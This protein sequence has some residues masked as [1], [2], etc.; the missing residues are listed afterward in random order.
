MAGLGIAL[1]AEQC[2]RAVERQLA[3]QLLDADGIE[4]L[5]DIAAGVLRSQLDARSLAHALPCI[6]RVLEMAP[7]GCRRQLATVAALDRGLS[8]RILESRGRSPGIFGGAEA[9]PLA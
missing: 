3:G 4:D 1:D 6:L 8:Q 9:A 5:L 7:L 2:P